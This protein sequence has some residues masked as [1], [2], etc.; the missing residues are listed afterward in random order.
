MD[1]RWEA[2]AGIE[3]CIWDAG[4]AG[5]AAD[6]VPVIL[7]GGRL[8]EQG[9]GRH[10]WLVGVDWKTR[11]RKRVSEDRVAQES[12][13][14]GAGGEG[15]GEGAVRDTERVNRFVSKEKGQTARY[16]K[17][18]PPHID[19]LSAKLHNER[20]TASLLQA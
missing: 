20:E 6:D 3:F 1:R 9:G 12:R 4:P 10:G 18:E 14:D 19:N 7:V 13:E 2:D 11:G 15:A 16:I 17:Y 5:K 8:A